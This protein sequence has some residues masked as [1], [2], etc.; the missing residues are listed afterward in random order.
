MYIYIYY[1]RYVT[2]LYIYRYII[3]CRYDIFYCRYVIDKDIVESF[4]KYSLFLVEYYIYIYICIYI[5]IYI[6]NTLYIC[7]C[8]SKSRIILDL[9]VLRL[10]IVSHTIQQFLTIY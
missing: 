4:Y 3:Y 8:H 1:C 2:L 5:Y 10:S 6:Y 9:C 7:I